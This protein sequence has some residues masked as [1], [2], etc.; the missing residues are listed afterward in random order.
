MKKLDKTYRDR[1]VKVL[2]LD[3]QE[4]PESARAFAQEKKLVYTVL[5]D[6]DGSVARGLGCPQFPSISS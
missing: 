4:P 3:V 5:W 2:A 6:E 1:G